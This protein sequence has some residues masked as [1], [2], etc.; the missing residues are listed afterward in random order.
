[1]I[2]AAYKALMKKYHPD[3]G[4]SDAR[5]AATITEAF[6]VLKDPEKRADY[7][8]RHVL[9][10]RQF[11]TP[12][13]RELPRPPRTRM[14][15]LSGWIAA[16][17]F[18]GAL[19]F[20]VSRENAALQRAS[21]E[22]AAAEGGSQPASLPKGSEALDVDVLDAEAMMAEAAKAPPE[23]APPPLKPEALAAP[24]AANLPEPTAAPAPARRVAKA[25]PHR[26]PARTRPS[27]RQDPDFLEREGYIY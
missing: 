6:T 14:F 20:T 22:I 21:T 15:A 10:E 7:H 1:V 12:D 9:A 23:I 2:E 26:K 18:G 27:T 4:A 24:L 17:A 19:A 13:Q 25:A 16:L 11:M 3:T 8:L 5:R